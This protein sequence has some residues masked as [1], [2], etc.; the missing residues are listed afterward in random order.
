MSVPEFT[1]AV[2]DN[3]YCW[4]YLDAV[5]DDKLH[6]LTIIVFIGSVFSPY[7]AWARQRGPASALQHCAVNVAL[8]GR[9]ARWC[10]TERTG[11]AVSADSTSLKIG[12]SQILL[13][14]QSMIVNID[15]VS[16]PLPSRVKGRIEIRLP[17]H[18][19]ERQPLDSTDCASARHYWQPIAPHSRIIVEMSS[20]KLAW[21][22]DAYVDSNYGDIPL[23]SSF[24][25]WTWSRS[26]AA[27][28]ETNIHY[29]VAMRNGET[30][31]RSLNYSRQGQLRTIDAP[32]THKLK[33]T[34]YFRITRT[35]RTCENTEICAL[36]TLEDT[37]FY[38]RSRFIEKD[39]RPA[40]SSQK[41][42]GT[43]AETAS[44]KVAI[45][46]SLDLDRFDSAW[47]R[48]LLPFRM[49]RKT[50]AILLR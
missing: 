2:P 38:S 30:S 9:P 8:Y 19:L 17:S 23:E 50:R 13:A 45:H 20:P 12:N 14:N 25:S 35:A 42:P 27:T 26:H 3:G 31:Q 36:Q 33:P 4:W 47:V 5:S 49:P 10:M 44:H 37:P 43:E 7:Y 15:E 21:E 22:G 40:N 16:V 29:D 24:K 39:L 6:A 34:R 48:C 11:T 41:P 46:E 32:R 28:G 18:D 1:H